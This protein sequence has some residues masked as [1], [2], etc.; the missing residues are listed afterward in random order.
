MRVTSASLPLAEERSDL[1]QRSVLAVQDGFP[2][3]RW[4]I[5]ADTI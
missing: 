1:H 3:L 4:L 5:P 2:A